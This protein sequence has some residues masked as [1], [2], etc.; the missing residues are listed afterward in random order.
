VQTV[1]NEATK[2]EVQSYWE[3]K[4]CGS[5]HAD[6][7]PGTPEFFA[8]VAAA[9]DRLEPYIADFAGFDTTA[10]QKVLEIGVGLG[11][12]HIRFARAG[13]RL[14]GVDLTEA[15]IELTRR[16]LALEG[17]SSNLRRADA[18]SLPFPDNHF[19]V[20]YSWGVLHHTPD[21]DQAIREAL[22]VLRPG[23]RACLMLYARRS[24]VGFGLWARYA[25]LRGR[26]WRSASDVFAHHLESPGTRAFTRRELESRL[27][28]LEDLQ[29]DR[30]VSPADRRVSGPLADLTGR[31]M[32]FYFVVR[33]SRA[34]A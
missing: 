12:D 23:G 9:R 6:T 15:S 11:S 29:L 16:R 2:R 26:P 5:T 20:V 3:V 30:A 10:G 25:L 19:D 32:G 8:Q 14:T 24:W 21:S 22:R 1:E 31:W 4:P 18:E 17:L 33:G 7:T 13:A 28:G 34:Q 27:G